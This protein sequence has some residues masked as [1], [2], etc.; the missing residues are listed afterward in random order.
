MIAAANAQSVQMET[1]ATKEKGR[2]VGGL[3]VGLD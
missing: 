2:H 1:G 3:K